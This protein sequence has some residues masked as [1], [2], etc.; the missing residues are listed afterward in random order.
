M[1]TTAVIGL[2][3]LVWVL[4][5]MLAALFVGRMIRMRD[6]HRPDWTEPGT[7]AEGEAADATAERRP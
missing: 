3:I 6:R 5:A 1:S 7:P 4:L 2:G